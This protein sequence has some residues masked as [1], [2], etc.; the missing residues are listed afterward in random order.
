ME[1]TVGRHRGQRRQ[2]REWVDGFYPIQYLA[3]VCNTNPG[4]HIMFKKEGTN[5]TVYPS[6]L[7]VSISDTNKL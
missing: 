5:A 7:L 6:E 2:R 3:F 4:I 1:G